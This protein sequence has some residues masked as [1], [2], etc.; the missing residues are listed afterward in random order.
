M[1]IQD[2]LN[3]WSPRSEVLNTLPNK[4]HLL[5]LLPPPAL[6]FV[7]KAVA[8]GRFRTDL[9]YGLN[10]YP[11]TVP[12]LRSR[13][14]DVLLLVQ[15]FVSDIA[16]RIGRKIAQTP[17]RIMKE[18]QSYDWPGNIRELQNLLERA[19]I[20][21]PD[22]VLRLPEALVSTSPAIRRS[23]GSKAELIDLQSV[24][25]RHVLKVLKAVNWRIR[26]PKGAAKIFGLNPS[27]LRFR[28][29]KLGIRKNA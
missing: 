10:V 20:T 28:M 11:I 25:H 27:T 29:K 2:C 18:L 26:G 16:A 8:F 7:K 6:A 21:S 4:L 23:T 14:E 13:L 19:V 3:P 22:S 24:E 9:F 17:S 1:S 12:P 15:H 5:D